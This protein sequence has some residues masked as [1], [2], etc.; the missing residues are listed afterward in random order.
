MTELGESSNSF[1]GR[2]IGSYFCFKCME[3]SV[4]CGIYCSG[5]WV[6]IGKPHKRL[7]K[8]SGKRIGPLELGY[9]SR[10]DGKQLGSGCILKVK[11]KGFSL[12][13]WTA[14]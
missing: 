10:G 13:H 2:V 3:M 5:P 12:V 7:L 11:I 6:N 9:S 4:R 1:S 14:V 8:N